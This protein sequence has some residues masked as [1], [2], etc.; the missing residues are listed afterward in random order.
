MT[1]RGN[2]IL[3][4]AWLQGWLDGFDFFDDYSRNADI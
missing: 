2:A 1:V 3:D 4:K